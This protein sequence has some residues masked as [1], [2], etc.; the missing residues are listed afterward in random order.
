MGLYTLIFF[1]SCGD[2]PLKFPQPVFLENIEKIP[3]NFQ[4]SFERIDDKDTIRNS[5]IHW[6]VDNKYRDTLMP[7]YDELTTKIREVNDSRWRLLVDGW[8]AFQYTE[9]D[10]SY[11]GHYNWHVDYVM[12][13]SN[14]PLSR[15][16]S[17]SLGISD[18]DDY[19]GGELST[20]MDRNERSYKLD[21]G[22]IFVFPSWMLHKVTPV[23]K[24]KRKVIVGWG[25]GPVI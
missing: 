3:S 13:P 10:E 8:D 2:I 1:T 11:K 21:K 5:R 25:L 16:I 9:Y 20:K 14:E 15:K 22:E 23:T 19:E 18:I 17:F 6:M 24:G 12:T 7:L 4:G